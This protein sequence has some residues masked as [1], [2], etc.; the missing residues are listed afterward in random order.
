M[1]NSIFVEPEASFNERRTRAETD[2]FAFTKA[3]PNIFNL[4]RAGPQRLTTVINKVGRVLPSA[5]KKERVANKRR[6]MIRIGELIRGGKLRRF[7]RVYVAT[8]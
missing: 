4:L 5:S 1:F 8:I 7:K 3:D 6:T 2:P